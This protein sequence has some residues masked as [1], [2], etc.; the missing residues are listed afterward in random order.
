MAAYE[1]GGFRRA[2]DSSRL[3]K[4]IPRRLYTRGRNRRA[5]VQVGQ[6]NLIC[7]ARE[8][9]GPITVSSA[10]KHISKNIDWSIILFTDNFIICRKVTIK[11]NI[12]KFQMYLN[13]LGEWVGENGIEINPGKCK[14][15]RFTRTRFKIPLGYCLG[16]QKIP[17]MSS[18]K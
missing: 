11:N 8:R 15:I 17:E 7:V 16:N 6:S 2:F 18:C 5:N 10:R 13:I 3:G 1:T 14:E 9:F 4:G 12:E